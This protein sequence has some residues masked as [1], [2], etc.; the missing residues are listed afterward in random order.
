MTG[1]EEWPSS[2]KSGATGTLPDIIAAQIMQQISSG[3]LSPGENLANRDRAC[4]PVRR[5]PQ[6]GSGGH[7]TAAFGWGRRNQARTRRYR[8][9]AIA[10][11]NLPDRHGR[12]LTKRRTWPICSSCGRCLEIDAAG[13]GRRRDT[14]ADRRY[15]AHR[16]PPLM[17]WRVRRILTR[18]ALRQ[19][20]PSIARS[21]TRHAEPNTS[22][23]SSTTFRPG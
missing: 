2:R 14:D 20:R 16:R 15:R 22:P 1:Q 3:E 8:V 5:E 13:S 18:N 17:K 4:R 9:A 19:T 23:R 10:P 7:C 12:R 11:G 6:R 21:D